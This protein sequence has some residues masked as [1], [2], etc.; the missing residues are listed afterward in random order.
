MICGMSMAASA[1]ANGP[2]SRQHLLPAQVT[3]FDLVELRLHLRREPDVEH[4]G[5]AA[6][7]HF[8][9]HLALRRRLKAPS[10]AVAYQRVRSVEMMAAYVDGRP[11]PSRSSSFTRLASLNRGA[12]R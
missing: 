11:M 8:P 10:L 3:L 4:L 6:L 1:M 12:A 5:E 7:H 9:H 2:R